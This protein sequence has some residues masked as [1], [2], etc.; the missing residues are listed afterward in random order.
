MKLARCELNHLCQALECSY[1]YFAGVRAR[2]GQL[3]LQHKVVDE[4]PH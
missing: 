3:Q 1:D 4:L 2:L